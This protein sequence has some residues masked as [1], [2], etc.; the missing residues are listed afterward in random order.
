M[1]RYNISSD[2]I[3][4]LYKEV[5]KETRDFRE[6]K[7]EILVINP[8]KVLIL[9]LML[10]LS[11]N[12]FEK[13]INKQSKNIAKYETGKIKTMQL[14]TASQIIEKTINLIEPV[15]F[16][17][18]LQNFKK[19]KEESNGWFK[20]NN[21]SLDVLNARR[22]GAIESLRNRRTPQEK[23]LEENL[24]EKNEE[25]YVNFPLTDNMIVDFYIPKK[26]LVIECKEVISSS[27]ME[28]KEQIQKL[29]YQGYRIKFKFPHKKLSGLIKTKIN[30]QSYE[31]EEL[32]GPFDNIFNDVKNLTNDL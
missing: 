29:A 15:N 31:K 18:V 23:I 30:L 20:A 7:P 27:R 12:K 3:R 1:P 5:E 11:Q 14:S 21:E 13:L 10:G 28:T 4:L 24:K 8:R 17:T 19:L 26:N 22:K 6:I 2:E 9:R 32:Q 16:E 25:F